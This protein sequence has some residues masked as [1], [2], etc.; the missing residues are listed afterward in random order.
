VFPLGSTDPAKDYSFTKGL[1]SRSD[2]SEIKMAYLLALKAAHPDK[3][4]NAK[5]EVIKQAEKVFQ[6]LREQYSEYQR[7]ALR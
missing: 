6:L 4:N 7:R 5:P 3:H 1:S 2:P